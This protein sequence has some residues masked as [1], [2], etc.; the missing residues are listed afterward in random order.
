MYKKCALF[1]TKSNSNCLGV[2]FLT[3]KQGRFVTGRI[4]RPLSC[5]NHV[6]VFGTPIAPIGATKVLNGAK[7]R[8]RPHRTLE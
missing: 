6:E 1:T 2:M 3:E 4:T 7:C 8:F 5:R